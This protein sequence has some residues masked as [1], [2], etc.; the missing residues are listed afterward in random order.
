LQSIVDTHYRAFVMDVA[1]GRGVSSTTVRESFGEGRMVMAREAVKRGMADGVRS[2]TS[3]LESPGDARAGVKAE[4]EY[5]QLR[6]RARRSGTSPA[7]NRA[8]RR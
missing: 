6:A 8:A 5:Y 2:L 1:A 3:I 4:L 7:G